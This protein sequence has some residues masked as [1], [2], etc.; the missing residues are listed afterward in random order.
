ML[1]GTLAQIALLR[2]FDHKMASPVL[3]NIIRRLLPSSPRARYQ[4]TITITYVQDT[5]V[6]QDE[7]VNYALVKDT[8]SAL[9]SV[10]N[11]TESY[12]INETIK[13]DDYI[14]L[15]VVVPILKMNLSVR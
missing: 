14:N 6:E 12:A 13:N 2:V 5:R 9:Y 7:V 15:T 10:S 11:G 3:R 1:S 4:S 8:D